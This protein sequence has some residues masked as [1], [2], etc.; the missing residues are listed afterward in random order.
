MTISQTPIWVFVY[1]SV[2]GTYCLWA[3]I[4]DL[5]EKR[6]SQTV[7]ELSFNTAL[8]IP[9]AVYWRLG[10]ESA[11]YWLVLTCYILGCASLLFQTVR[12]QVN[13]FP[14][15]SLSVAANISLSIFGWLLVSAMAGPSIW[16]GW[17]WLTQ[18]PLG[19]G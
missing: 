16:W 18:V 19:S 14:D 8:V 5:R 6:W 15:A 10:L 13:S 1:F 17:L 12:A 3:N 9:A 7:I 2:Y 4:E 11:P